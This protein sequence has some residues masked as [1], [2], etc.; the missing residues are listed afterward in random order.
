MN[1]SVSL[2]KYKYFLTANIVSVPFKSNM[3]ARKTPKSDK[4]EGYLYSRRHRCRKTTININLKRGI[5]DT[6]SHSY[7]QFENFHSRR[8]R[9][10]RWRR[11]A[12]FI[13]RMSCGGRGSFHV[14]PYAGRRGATFAQSTFVLVH[15]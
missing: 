8:W 11:F 4:N 2:S 14:F 13:S 1:I 10:R 12:R 7:I 9:R 5:R 15:F 3:K 6:I